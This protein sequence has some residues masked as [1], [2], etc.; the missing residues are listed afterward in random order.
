M[1]GDLNDDRQN[2]NI[3]GAHDHVHNNGGYNNEVI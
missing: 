2:C 1:L 3:N